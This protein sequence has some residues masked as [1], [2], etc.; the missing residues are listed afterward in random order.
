MYPS[1]SARQLSILL[2]TSKELDIVG[3]VT[4]TVDN[5]SEL[6][7]WAYVLPKPTVCAWR[8][9]SG[10]PFIQLTA[11]YERDPIRGQVTAVLPCDAHQAFWHE[12]L[13]GKDLPQGQLHRLE[14]KNLSEAWA[15]MPLAPDA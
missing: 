11:A 14:V 15:A 2:R 6:L 8:G 5:P 13:L 7:A 1:D 3:D 12:L 4:A 9:D 10:K